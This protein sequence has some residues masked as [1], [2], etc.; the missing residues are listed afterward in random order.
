MADNKLPNEKP[1]DKLIREIREDYSY[2]RD[3][4]RENYDEAKTDLQFVGGDP[5]DTN[6]R[7]QRE[8]N[9][10]PVISPDELGQYLNQT[11][12]NLRQNARAIKVTPAGDEAEDKDAEQR[13]AIIKGIEYKSNAQAA[14]TNAFE[15][16]INCGFGFFR[17]TT[18]KVGK[19]GE[20]EPRI[21][22]IEN[23]LSVLLDPNAKEFDFSDMKRCFVLDVMRQSDFERKYPKAKKRSFSA[24][25]AGTAPGWLQGQNITIAEYWRIDDYDE[26]G[27]GGTVTQYI[28]NGFEILDETEWPGSRIPIISVLGKKVYI[29]QGDQMHRMYYSMVRLARPCQK[30]LAYIASQEAEEYGMAP[31][32]P[33]MGY[34][35]QFETDEEAWDNLN[36]VPRSRIQVDPIVDQASGQ[37]LPLPTRLPFTP[38]YAAYEAGFERWRRSLQASMGIS[39]LPTAAQRQNEKS[40]VALEKIQTQQAVGSFHFTDNFD[41]SLENAGRQINE[42][43]TNVLDTERQVAVRNPDETHA[44]M[45]IVPGGG[46][47]AAQGMAGGPTDAQDEVFD[48]SKGQFDVIISTGPSYQSQREEATHFADIIIAELEHLPIAPMQKSSLLSLA[49]KLKNLG[50]LGDEMAKI[51]DPQGDQ[52][53]LPPQVQ[54]AVSNMQQ[55]MQA[56]QGELSKLTMERQAKVLEHHGKMEEIAAKSQADMALEDKKLLTAVT[57]AEINTKAQ[58]AADREADRRALEMQFHTQAAN[59][60]E[61]AV[62]HA[63]EISMGQQ[64][65]AQQ[66]MQSAQDAS[67]QQIPDASS[68]PAQ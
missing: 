63:H 44:L 37:I 36:K 61:Q 26:D 10:R 49:I 11:I 67:Q 17:V 4:W 22:I 43:I 38:N 16:A 19:S 39:P 58:N 50:P 9:D 47:A 51:I 48:P 57:V 18:K 65:A 32:A 24:Q 35:G 60:A 7:R 54:A 59:A 40:G 12:N 27:E 8:D 14:Y 53:P 56:M 66:S 23:P 31:R 28:T 15:C 25:D 5:W 46:K 21:K 62:D 64:N 3:F 13:S 52:T 2:F 29:P 6:S 45:K 68:V 34:T 41:R 20:V 30:M 33:I 1:E 55:N 42:L